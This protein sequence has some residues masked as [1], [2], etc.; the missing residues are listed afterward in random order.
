M[1]QRNT[2]RKQSAR[3]RVAAEREARKRSAQRRRRLLVITSVLVVLGA[4]TGIGIAVSTSSSKP[5]SYAVPSN[6]SVVVDK[7]ADPA[8]KPTALAYGPASAP[9]TLTIFE[10]FRCPFCKGLETGSASV[11]K[12]YVAAGTLRVL[13]H[14]VTLLDRN[15]PGSSGS[16]WS[17][18][19]S[20]CA[21]TAGKFD[22]YHDALYASQ[23]DESTDTYSDTAKLIAVAKQVPGLDTPAFESCVTAGTY[24]GLVQQNMADFDTLNL[25]ATPT[26]IL[27]GK[28]L[29]LPDSF[30]KLSADHKTVLGSDPAQLKAV[31]QAAGLP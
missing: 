23:P 17:G 11:Y 9:H 8:H 22:E 13:F 12:S 1:S 27:D 2:A 28:K 10:D 20:V 3:E 4:A 19:A 14:P 6:G 21:A 25:E 26:L 29:T 15:H 30:Y 31:L 7:Y 18:A 16:L 5:Q 24:K